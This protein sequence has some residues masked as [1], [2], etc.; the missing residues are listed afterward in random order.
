MDS[1]STT[2]DPHTPTYTDLTPQ[3]S[4]ASPDT[5]K[6]DRPHTPT[7]L[8]TPTRMGYNG[9]GVGVR[10][11]P[12]PSPSKTPKPAKAI[13]EVASQQKEVEGLGYGIELDEGTIDVSAE[14]AGEGSG[15][16]S[17]DIVLDTSDLVNLD[18][19]KDVRQEIQLEMEDNDIEFPSM[20]ELK[21]YQDRLSGP[22]EVDNKDLVN[23]VRLP[24]NHKCNPLTRRSTP[25]WN[26]A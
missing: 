17:R 21:A 6:K 25:S 16:S 3:L 8:Q 18:T 7:I 2:N 24:Y 15:S 1:S 4:S 5:P 22:S 9:I 26:H 14:M 19:T 20:E 23:M 13:A 12:E 10:P 11:H